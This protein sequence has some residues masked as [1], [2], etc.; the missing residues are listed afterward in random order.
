MG[1]RALAAH[2]WLLAVLAMS[3]ISW[4]IACYSVG[5]PHGTHPTGFIQYDQGYYMAEAR[6]HFADG[7][8][9]FYGS[10]ASSDYDTPRVYFHP[11]TFLLGALAKFTNVE[12]G[13]YRPLRI[14]CWARLSRPVYCP[15]NFSLGWRT[16]RLIRSFAQVDV[17]RR[18][19]H[20]RHRGLGGKPRP[21]GHL[22]H[23]RLL[24][25]AV[26][27]SDSGLASAMVC[28]NAPSGGCH[29]CKPPLHRDG[30][31]PYPLW[32]DNS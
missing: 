6:Q 16:N 2:R 13:C 5:A 8:H 12:P 17:G 20:L 3:P 27:R 15:A 22:R 21:G 25:R 19:I 24:S 18:H 10:P 14:R 26:F 11:Q 32:L 9:L 28:N 29:L 30:T 31:W 4:L 1:I 23:R 7:F